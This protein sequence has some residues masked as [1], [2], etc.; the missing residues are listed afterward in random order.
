VSAKVWFWTGG[1]T[2]LGVVPFLVVMLGRLQCWAWSLTWVRVFARGVGES[3]VNWIKVRETKLRGGY[4][5]VER[6]GMCLF[7]IDVMNT[8]ITNTIMQVYIDC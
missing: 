2:K 7:H 1:V 5:R 6:G 4:G 8:L 3:W